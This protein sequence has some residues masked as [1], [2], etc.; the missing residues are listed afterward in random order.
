MKANKQT[1]IIQVLSRFTENIWSWN[2]HHPP[3]VLLFIYFFSVR[4]LLG[5]GQIITL[6]AEGMTLSTPHTL[7]GKNHTRPALPNQ[8]RHHVIDSAGRATRLT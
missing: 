5:K 2:T 1:N 3:T 8:A 7:K 6:Q 4:Q